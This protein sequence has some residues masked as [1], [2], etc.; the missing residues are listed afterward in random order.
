MWRYHCDQ[1]KGGGNSVLQ[2]ILLLYWW[3]GVTAGA[4]CCSCKWVKALRE[5]PLTHPCSCLALR[6]ARWR[7]H[8]HALLEAGTGPFRRQKTGASLWRKPWPQHFHT[9]RRNSYRNLHSSDKLFLDNS[10]R[11]SGLQQRAR[12]F[13][14]MKG[15]FSRASYIHTH[16]RSSPHMC[17]CI[18]TANFSSPLPPRFVFPVT[19]SLSYWCILHFVLVHFSG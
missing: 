5:S 11:T 6:I 8:F 13:L 19:K 9:E 18:Q 16:S 17:Y 15:H 12:G 4:W 2:V 10:S 14:A 7:E 1:E 3:H